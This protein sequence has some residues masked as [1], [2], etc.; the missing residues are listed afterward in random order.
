MSH[1]VGAENNEV[2]FMER[3]KTVLMFLFYIRKNSDLDIGD[4]EGGPGAQR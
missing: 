4:L 2:L 3:E 1:S